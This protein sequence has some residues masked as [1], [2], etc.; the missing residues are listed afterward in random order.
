MDPLAAEKEGQAS[1][2]NDGND[3]VNQGTMDPMEEE[4][5]DGDDI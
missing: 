4:G 3:P 1:L 5:P 2:A